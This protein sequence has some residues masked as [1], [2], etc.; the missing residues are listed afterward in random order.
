VHVVIV[1]QG[2]I[3]F[4]RFP[5]NHKGFVIYADNIAGKLEG[6]V[7]LPNPTPSLVVYKA[8]VAALV[9]A[10][11]QATDGAPTSI[12]DRNAKA[13]KVYQDIGHIVDY[14]QTVADTQGSPADAVALIVGA[15]LEVQKPRKR[16]TRDLSVRYLGISGAVLL[17]ALAVEG[18]GAYYWEYSLDQKVWATPP[19]T[20]TGK[21]TIT[22][23][24]PGQVYYFRFRTLTGKGKGDYSQVVSLMMH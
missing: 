15:G 22:G 16:K 18:A 3:A 4:A 6:N 11:A 21:T 5:R 20:R 8:D 14:V 23:L 9:T 12:A 24:T 1:Y 19:E 10:Q 13:L 2:P 7:D 17:T